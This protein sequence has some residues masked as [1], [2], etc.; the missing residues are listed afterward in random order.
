MKK[1]ITITIFLLLCLGIK[2]QDENKNKLPK[3]F[4]LGIGISNWG[5]PVYVGAE[6]PIGEKNQTL[7]F[8][9]SYQTQTETYGLWFGN[10]LKWRH[11]IIGISGAYNYYFDELVELDSKFDLYA[12]IGLGLYIWRTKLTDT[13]NGFNETYSGTG[14]GGV[15]IDF[16]AGVRYHLNNKLALNARFGGGSILSSGRFGLS[17][18]F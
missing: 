1:A 13:Y 6:F 8:D 17:L 2:A 3:F 5:I 4:N 10:E 11:T 14:S 18:K 9:A 12:G 7:S 16:L 15:G